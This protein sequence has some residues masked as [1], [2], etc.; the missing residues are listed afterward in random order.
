[1][2]EICRKVGTGIVVMNR[3]KPFVPDETLHTIYRALVQPYFDYCSPIWDNC[4]LLLKDKLQRFQN[5]GARELTG[6]HYDISSSELLEQL[7]WKNLETQHRSNKAVL[8]YNILNNGT[9]PGLREFFSA[10]SLNG[11]LLE[12]KI[13]LNKIFYKKMARPCMKSLICLA[14]VILPLSS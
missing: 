5:R 3:I 6:A 11:Y 12:G 7:R 4:R 13:C 14:M 1:M 8:V 10:Q 2:N 9:A